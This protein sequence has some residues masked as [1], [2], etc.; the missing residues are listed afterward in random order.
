MR[1]DARAVREVQCWSGVFYRFIMP[2]FR[3]LALATWRKAVFDVSI[4]RA[5]GAR[6]QLGKNEKCA[7]EASVLEH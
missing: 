2:P 5:D 6:E 4:A 7:N 1:V 3:A